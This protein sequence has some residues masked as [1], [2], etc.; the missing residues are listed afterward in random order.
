[1]IPPSAM[2]TLSVASAQI[3]SGDGPRATLPRIDAVSHAA[4]LLGAEVVL[5]PEGSVHGYD[6]DMTESSLRA[7]AEPVGGP[8][9]AEVCAIARRRRIAV[10]AGIFEQDAGGRL[11][12]TH[13]IAFPD[14]RL[15]A[16]RKHNIT[17]IETKANVSPGPRKRTVFTLN[18][19]RCA[20]MICADNG[21]EGLPDDLRRDRVELRFIPAGAGGDL[22]AMLHPADLSDPAARERYAENRTHVCMTTPF[23]P[24]FPK[25]GTGFV[26]CNALGPAGARTC[27][28]GHCMI[29]DGQGVLRAQAPGT[30][31][32]EHMAEQLITAT[33][34]FPD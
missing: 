20:V 23:D 32:R 24:E 11:Y 1:M 28:Q 22:H 21:I 8:S 30:I 33:L 15:L 18:G 9:T 4:A 16:Q 7:L 17:G 10:L 12:N 14:G 29:V 31:V 13:L 2:K 25:W 6:Y 3:V 26:S 34:E 19:V 5:F 27:H